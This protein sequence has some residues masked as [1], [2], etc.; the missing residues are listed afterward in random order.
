MNTL[1]TFKAAFLFLALFAFG[2]GVFIFEA[3][4]APAAEARMS[5]KL[6]LKS[7]ARLDGEWYF[8]VWDGS[9]DTT[10]WV[11]LGGRRPHGGISVDAYNPDTNVALVS[12]QRGRF[13]VVMKE[14]DSSG[15]IEQKVVSADNS[16][17]QVERE[18]EEAMAD[19]DA[20]RQTRVTRRQILDMI[21]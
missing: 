2:G 1:R 10:H 16:A 17:D 8:S 9:S 12:T 14:P 5:D 3:P 15:E 4:C 19:L 18:L 13:L 7:V 21:K 11:K 20:P 6:K